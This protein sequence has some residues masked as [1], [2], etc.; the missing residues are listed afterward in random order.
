LFTNYGIISV[1]CGNCHF[2]FFSHFRIAWAYIQTLYAFK[3]KKSVPSFSVVFL[4][5]QFKMDSL[6]GSNVSL[7]SLRVTK[8]QKDKIDELFSQQGWNVNDAELS[9]RG[10]QQLN[11]DYYRIPQDKEA[12][13][14]PFCLCQ[15]CVTC[16]NNRQLW[17]E[18]EQHEPSRQNS[19]KRKEHY[20]R[21]WTCLLHRGVWQHPHY[22]QRKLERLDQNMDIG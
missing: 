13:L 22:L 5:N 11:Y 9:T 15:P 20:R 7:I 17:W 18:D 4:N 19:K 16:E 3:L 10:I 14:C 2:Q 21:F 1:I 8:E 12:V 6:D